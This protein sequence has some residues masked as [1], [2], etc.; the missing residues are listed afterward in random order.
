ME[1]SQLSPVKFKAT[2][3]PARP[4]PELETS[5]SEPSLGPNWK[6]AGAAALSAAGLLATPAAAQSSNTAQVKVMSLN[7]WLDCKEGVDGIA[8]VIRAGNPDVVGLQEI[9]DCAQPLSEKL[10]YQ[11][12]RQTD[13]KSMLTRLP[14]ES[15]TPARHGMVVRLSNGQPLAVFNAHLHHTPYQPYQ[16]LGIPY[17]DGAFIKSESEAQEQSRLAR[18]ADVQ[19]L[20]DDMATVDVPKVLTGD[21][22]EPSH[23]D[24]TQRAADSGRHP[25]KVE[26]PASKAFAEVGLK[27]SYRMV[28]PDEMTHPG[29][30]WTPHTRADDPKDHHDRLDFVMFGGPGLQA[31][32]VKIIGPDSDIVITPYPSDHRGVVAELTVTPAP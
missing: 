22:N 10:G 21:F 7:V 24:W 30:T 3:R 29:D 6:L 9:S 15:V 17:G 5:S 23:L 18:G 16:L 27:D 31:R 25:L 8:E 26:W 20:L 12:V 11:L 19:S 28:F 32:D 1:M 13:W 14:V 2:R 4:R